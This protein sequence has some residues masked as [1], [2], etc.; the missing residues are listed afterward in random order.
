M[1]LASNFVGKR[2]SRIV[3]DGTKYKNIL[4]IEQPEIVD[5]YNN[6]MGRVDLLDQLRSYYRI[7]L[8]SKKLTL[9]VIFIL[10][11]WQLIKLH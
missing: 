9:R 1:H 7:F 6:D 10:L 3:K 4:L 11:T 8:K 5:A 2:Q